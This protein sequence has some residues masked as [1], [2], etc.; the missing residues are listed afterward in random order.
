MW[1]KHNPVRARALV[2]L[3]RQTTMTPFCQKCP[4][5]I[6]P[7]CPISGESSALTAQQQRAQV[8]LRAFDVTGI[9][10]AKISICFTIYLYERVWFIYGFHDLSR[11]NIWKAARLLREQF[12]SQ[13][14]EAH[15][16]FNNRR[17]QL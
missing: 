2:D 14:F 5:L 3:S 7:R 16:F 11:F 8:K 9:E 1:A 17:H 13:H 10:A 6:Q 4:T 12:A 15:V